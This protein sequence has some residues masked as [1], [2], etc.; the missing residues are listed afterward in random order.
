MGLNDARSIVQWLVSQRLERGTVTSFG[1]ALQDAAKIFSEG[2]GVEGADILKTKGGRH[3]H[4]QVKSGPNTI[5]KDL[6]VRI[7]QLLRSAQRR[8]LGSVALFGMCYGS[9]QQV[10]GIVRQYVEQEGG[11]NWLTG[12]EFWEFISGD[13]DCIDEIYKVAAEAGEEFRD[14]RNQALSEILEAKIEELTEQ[15]ER[16]YGKSDGLMWENLLKRNS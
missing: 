1:I 16:L 14:A 4:I 3:Y 6:G 9:K 15:F 2:T 10:S 5:P 13:P 12:R 8:N 11:I 7:S